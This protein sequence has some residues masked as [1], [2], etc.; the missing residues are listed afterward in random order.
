MLED[1][2]IQEGN[3]QIG[4]FMELPQIKLLSGK[5]AFEI[6][7]NFFQ[8]QHLKYHSSWDWLMPVVEKIEKCTWPVN[9][10][11]QIYG[12]DGHYGCKITSN[13]WPEGDGINAHDMT[14][15]IEVVWQAVIQFIQWYNNQSK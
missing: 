1:K 9:L 10:Y 11:T 4:L 7:G 5:P 15:K 14:S 8:A 6:S 12:D 3:W 2:E 13:N